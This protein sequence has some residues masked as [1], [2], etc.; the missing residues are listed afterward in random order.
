[1]LE[2]EL[3]FQVPALRRAAVRRFVLGRGQVPSRRIGLQ[4][5]YF[6]TPDR[7]L[8]QAGIA[9]RLRREGRQWVQTLKGAADDGLSREEHNIPLAA[10][11]VQRSAPQADPL[12]HADAAVGKRLLKLLEAGPG[13]ALACI[14]RTDIRRLTRTLRS[15]YG[16]VELALDEGWLLA[17]ERR[18]AV[19]ELEIEL[20]S[21]HPLAV[22]EVARRWAPRLG[23]W[24]DTRSKAE[25]GD[26]LSRGAS[27]AAPR[28]GS[29]VRLRPGQSA[30]E[31]LQGV[32]AVCRPQ[33][34]VNAAQIGSGEFDPEHLH[35]L[36]VGLRRLRSA[37]RLFDNDP[38]AAALA[39]P[40]TAPVT[41]L[42]RRLGAARDGAVM[43]GELAHALG[44]ALRG[45][46]A[47]TE[48]PAMVCQEKA[49]SPTAVLREA[50]SQ[51]LLLDLL[52]ATLPPAPVSATAALRAVVGT[53]PGVPPPLQSA[54]PHPVARPRLRAQ[55]A[56]RLSRWHR[57]VLTDAAAFDQLD[58]AARH[59]L[60][61][62]I[63]RL[64]YAAEFAAGLF[65]AA[66]V[67]CSLKPLRRVQARL[68]ALN[69]IA[70][71]L[72]A[73]DAVK[74]QDPRAWFALGWLAARREELRGSARSDLKALT[75]AARFWKR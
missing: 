16:V 49:E 3:K 1:M 66:R 60:R 10:G 69:D 57:D 44:H 45:I 62:R 13:D 40:L 64:R 46:G 51:D 9:L 71:A 2:I 33:V 50:G 25:R 29:Q 56:R 73:F 14:Y 38:D 47:V 20:L 27:M 34:L 59:R 11:E 8:A 31:A 43:E 61:K 5:A 48:L 22:L 36:R 42:F 30:R 39:A 63:K 24:L 52:A 58:D 7:V 41:R 28:L 72:Q 54:P 53:G 70:V 18:L 26:M 68:G 32:I 21:G 12:R 23:M 37:M 75:K 65:D 4:A 19:C 6:D 35:Q 67:R 15:R 17:G 55:L 74:A